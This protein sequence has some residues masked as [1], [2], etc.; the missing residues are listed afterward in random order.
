MHDVDPLR[1]RHERSPNARFRSLCSRK[2]PSHEVDG[3]DGHANAEENSGEDAFR[4]AFAEGEGEAGDD[5][6]DEGEPARDGAGERLLED[7]DGVL[8][9]RSA[10]RLGECRCGEEETREKRQAHSEGMAPATDCSPAYFHFETSER[11][12]NRKNMRRK[13]THPDTCW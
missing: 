12:L 3:G 7:T 1:I 10:G 8:P 5:N 2:E 4:A 9:G 13:S 11:D 6:R